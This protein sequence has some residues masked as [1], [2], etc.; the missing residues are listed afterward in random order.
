MI[1]GI[2]KIFNDELSSI[3]NGI[4][5]HFPFGEMFRTNPPQMAPKA[6][7]PNKNRWTL[8]KSC[9]GDSIICFLFQL[10]QF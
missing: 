2:E 7:K 1:P 8:R 6:R 4:P 9:D 10:P 5:I 3:D